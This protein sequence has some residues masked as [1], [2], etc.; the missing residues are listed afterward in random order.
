MYL[1]IDIREMESLYKEL[2]KEGRIPINIG[3]PEKYLE[4]VELD[5]KLKIKAKEKR[6]L[7]DFF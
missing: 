3:N 1:F 6:T 7:R 4:A 5:K 2:K